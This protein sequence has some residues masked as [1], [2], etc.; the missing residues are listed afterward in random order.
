MQDTP[1]FDH[2][3]DSNPGLLS[4]FGGGND[5]PKRFKSTVGVSLGCPFQNH[6]KRGGLR[7]RHTHLKPFLDGWLFVGHV[8]ETSSSQPV[9]PRTPIAT[10]RQSLAKPGGLSPEKHRLVEW[11]L[12]SMN[13]SG[14]QHAHPPLDGTVINNFPGQLPSHL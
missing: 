5:P 1:L 3:M 4:P 14:H 11:S 8:G 13:H 2:P 12:Q 6:S 7:K 10:P 9:I